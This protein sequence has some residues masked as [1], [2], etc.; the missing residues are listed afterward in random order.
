MNSFISVFRSFAGTG[1]DE[2]A[3]FSPITFTNLSSNVGGTF[4]FVAP[5]DTIL[6][7]QPG[8]YL[9][10][11]G[12]HNQSAAL[13]DLKIGGVDQTPTPFS[14]DGGGPIVASII[15][16]VTTVPTTVQLVNANNTPAQLHNN[17]NATLT[18]IKLT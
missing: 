18:I 15:V 7:L 4:I 9:F 2:V 12:I 1:T 17:T 6:I 14:G 11:F 10:D 8:I 16:N 5:S 13:F 3:A